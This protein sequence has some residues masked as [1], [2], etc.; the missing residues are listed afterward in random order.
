MPIY[1]MQ[2][3]FNGGELSPKM[4]ARSDQD[5]YSSGMRVG[6]NGWLFPHGSFDRRPGFRFVRRTK[7]SV[8]KKKLIP[9]EF[10]TTQAYALEFGIGVDG[11]GYFRVFKGG[12][13]RGIV[14]IPATTASI[15]NG[16]FANMTG[17]TD[18]STAASTATAVS[19]A[20]NLN[21]VDT[22][23]PAAA[24]QQVNHTSGGVAHT[25]R[26][27]VT[28]GPV[29]LQVGS[30][31]GGVELLAKKLYNTGR[32]VVTFTPPG[33]NTS[34][35]LRFSHQGGVSTK[36]VTGVALM[37]DQPVEV[38]TPFTSVDQLFEAKYCQNADV[39][40]FT[41]KA[42]KPHRLLRYG[43]TVWSMERIPFGPSLPAPVNVAVTTGGTAG[44]TSRSYVVTACTDSDEESLRSV[45][46]TITTGNATLS[47]TNYDQI[48]WDDVAGATYY[49]VY[50]LV[51]GL[52]C[53]LGKSGD[54]LY[55]NT[56][57]YKA[58]KDQ[59]P[60]IYTDP[61]PTD[62]DNFQAVC[63]F[64]QRMMGAR[65]QIIKGSQTANYN[66][67]NKSQPLKDDD[68]VTYRI[69]ADRLNEIQWLSPGKKLFFGTSSGEWVLAGE[70]GKPLTPTSINTDR[71]SVR[72]SHYLQPLVI[73]NVMLFVARPGNTVREFKYTLEDDAYS[74]TDLAILSEHMIQAR[75][76][77][78]WA[79]QQMPLSIAWLVL[80]DG[81]MLSLHYN[82][83]HK[84]VGWTRH[85]TDG[86]FESICTI[87]GVHDDDVWVT[88]RRYVNGVWERSVEVLA[89]LFRE[90]TTEYAF[91]VDSG[92][93]YDVPKPI[94]GYTRANPCVVTCPG[95]GFTTG[96]KVRLT[97]MTTLVVKLEDG[98]A[99]GYERQEPVAELN[100]KKYTVT[101]VDADHFSLDGVDS[102]AYPAWFEGGNA[103][104]CVTVITGLDHVEGKQ[105]QILAD[106]AVHPAQIVTGGQITLQSPK[107]LVHVGLPYVTDLM[108]MKPEVK[109]ADGTIQSRPKSINKAWA[110]VYKTSTFKF[111]TDESNLSR[112]TVRSDLFPGGSALPLISADVELEVMGGFDYDAMFLIRQDQPLPLSVLALVLELEVGG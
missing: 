78:D 29:A 8:T 54:N 111:G 23:K 3:S 13:K 19:N 31:S 46:V 6:L 84:I 94:T 101:V 58:N 81:T 83:E 112:V 53:F 10:S 9:F 60:P 85:K 20:L 49:N 11:K 105:V 40:L 73:G 89:P 100:F 57:A 80:D 14:W 63:W 74:S 1:L 2:N 91:F 21:C 30:T 87:P 45:E 37:S 41:H 33:G 34:F 90:D 88:V 5:R 92:L 95:H 97:D 64:Q 47:T 65:D 86:R 16:D 18:K 69:A 59:N 68:A 107:S 71:E 70:N 62:A 99:P 28:D 25:M 55:Q 82:S 51:D 56:G 76:V 7:D 98:D 12:A 43:H 39:M 102:S 50:Q 93:T 27:E 4:D 79:Y 75:T 61:C 44:S 67:F 108:P 17:W 42:I 38:P 106:G 104:K 96:D 77:V 109:A 32:H 110:R 26:F 52:H 35:Y 22:T 36:K 24:E 66:N 48:T 15:Q 72:G 103:R